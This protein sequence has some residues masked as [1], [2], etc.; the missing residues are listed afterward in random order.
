LQTSKDIKKLIYLT[1]GKP[2]ILRNKITNIDQYKKGESIDERLINNKTKNKIMYIKLGEFIQD[3][4][5]YL[6]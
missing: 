2:D 3:I 1:N 6:S 5:N 4:D